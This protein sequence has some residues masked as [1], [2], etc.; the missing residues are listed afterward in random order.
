MEASN[1][2]INPDQ[3]LPTALE[4]WKLLDLDQKRTI[5]KNYPFRGDR[6][7]AIIKLRQRGVKINTLVEITGLKRATILRVTKGIKAGSA[8]SEME[9][10]DSLNEIVRFLQDFA[11]ELHEIKTTIIS[12]Y[13]EKK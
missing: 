2:S 1:L 11:K 8:V 6:N 12:N 9:T 7:Q 3:L 10:S 13:E 4:I 5:Q